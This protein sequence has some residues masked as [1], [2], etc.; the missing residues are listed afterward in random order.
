MTNAEKMQ[1]ICDYILF[2]QNSDVF[3]WNF[4]YYK[5]PVGSL[6]GSG[7]GYI[8]LIADAGIP[9]WK[10]K[11]LNS[12]DSPALLTEFGED[13]GYPLHNCY[14]DYEVGTDKWKEYHMCVYSKEDDMYFKAC[15]S[16]ETGYYDEPI[17][18]FDPNT[19]NFWGE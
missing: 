15:P 1:A 19:Y 10:T 18:M 13:L 7:G 5:I 11:R 6:P 2:D 3:S 17:V 12:S 9:F 8:F 14:A 16:M 4:R